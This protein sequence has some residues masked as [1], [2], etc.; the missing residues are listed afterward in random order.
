MKNTIFTT[1]QRG[2]KYV[3]ICRA[4]ST[5]TG[6]RHLCEMQ[7]ENGYTVAAGK[8]CYINRRW[9][10]YRFQTVLHDV[11]RRAHLCDD[12]QENQ[13]RQKR[14]MQQLDRKAAG[15]Y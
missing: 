15:R 6:F 5:R 3:F 10:S 2:Q 9:E 11:I 8:V 14:L 13:K 7:T 4:E 1:T 12:K